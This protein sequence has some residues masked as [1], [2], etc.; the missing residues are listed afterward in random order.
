MI[1]P[2]RSEGLFDQ[3]DLFNTGISIAGR[4]GA[5]VGEFVSKTTYIDG[6]DQT[7]LLL[8][9]NGESA[10]RS[11]PYTYNQY[12]AMMRVDEFKYVFT[13]EIQNGFVQ[14]GN[15]GGFSGTVATDTG[16][17][18]AFNLYTNPQEDV[19]IGIRH[20]PMGVPV[21]AAAGWYMKEL[22]KYPP[23]FKIGF[24]SNNPPIYDLIPKAKEAIERLQAE[25][26]PD[27]H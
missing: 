15:V 24:L 23:Q 13:A 27:P 11:R 7:G 16:G 12:F 6:V 18:V 3:A 1:K 21:I 10:R 2:R 8:A 9:D 4:P 14:K 5:Q 26:R 20:I 17:A 22:I 19:S 25:S